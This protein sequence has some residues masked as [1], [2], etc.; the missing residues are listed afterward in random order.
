MYAE[1]NV[2]EVEHK[3]RFAIVQSAKATSPT[4]EKYLDSKCS[5]L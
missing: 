2:P 1:F 5:E 3:E 4:E